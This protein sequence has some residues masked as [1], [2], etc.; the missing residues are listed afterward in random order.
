MSSLK[1]RNTNNQKTARQRPPPNYEIWHSCVNSTPA[2][3]SSKHR[4]RRPP[5]T[6]GQLDRV[7]AVEHAGGHGRDAVAEQ[8]AL[9]RKEADGAEGPVEVVVVDVGRDAVIN[10]VHVDDGSVRAL[11]A[12]DDSPPEAAAGTLEAE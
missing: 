10:L 7:V 3:P 8:D 2:S 11:V 6:H 5:L 1:E 12:R 4:Q 9:L